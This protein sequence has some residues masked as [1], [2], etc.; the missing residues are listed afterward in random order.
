M[1]VLLITPLLITRFLEKKV[2]FYPSKE[3]GPAPAGK[4]LE[5]EDV[6]FKAPD[7]IVLHGW[8][9]PANGAYATVIY[10]HGNAGNISHRV[11][12][13]RMFNEI[14]VNFFIFDY[15]G[16]GKSSGSPSEEGTYLDGMAA[17]KYL[18]ETRGILPESIVLYGKSLGVAVAVDLASKLKAGVLICESGFTSTQDMAR[19]FYKFIPLWLFVGQKYNSFAKIRQVHIP[20]LFMHSPKDEIIPF[21]HSKRMFERATGP[22]DLYVMKGG[23][24]DAFYFHKEETMKRISVFLN[25]YLKERRA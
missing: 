21:R 12:I 11:E 23:H 10:F 18:V 15:R 6:F 24:N 19:E 4:G 8:F 5:Y 3:I 25:K 7:G 17:Y 1:A 22:K 2:L 13:V 20:I 9:I 16:F 14:K